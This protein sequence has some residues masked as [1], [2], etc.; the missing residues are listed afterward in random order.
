MEEKVVGYVRV[1][2]EGQVRER[3]RVKVLK[4]KKLNRLMKELQ[5]MKK[6]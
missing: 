5:N 4:L 6:L 2:T 3:V 1:S